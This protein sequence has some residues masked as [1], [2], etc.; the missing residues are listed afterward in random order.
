MSSDAFDPAELVTIDQVIARAAAVIEPGAHTWAAAG[1]GQ[2]VTVARNARAL[3]RLALLPRLLR[4]VEAPDTSTSFLG[5]SMAIP[6]MLAPV[7]ALSIYHDHGAVAAAEAADA[8]GTIAFC[9]MLADDPWED[10]AATSP[11]RHFFQVYVAGDRA[12]LGEIIARAEAA[13][14]AGLCI[15]ADTPVIGRRDRSLVD[16]Y[17]WEPERHGHPGNLP[18]HGSDPGYRRRAGWEDLEWICASTRLPV[19]LKGVM[20]AADA[21]RAVECGVA[22]VYV[23][24]HGG[25]VV[26][27]SLSTIEV[28]EEIVD[29]VP[30][31]VAVDSGFARGP[32]VLK[33][34]AL[35]ARAVGIGRL[36]CWALACG[37]RAGVERVLAI[38]GEEI[39]ITMA[40]LG[41]PTVA[42]LTRDHV[43]WSFPTT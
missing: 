43:R 19:I 34:L 3:N 20:A 13:G 30:V 11:G 5:V 24:N 22:A 36:Q 29:A 42:D 21:V 41:C 37:G 15:T 33:A 1:A 28:L 31:E 39:G 14:Y 23:S 8:A 6:V 18:R 9:G 2:E 17:I 40:N 26:D 10:L 4:G 32:D 38:L 27:H 7:G 16:G 12:W 35:G 25:R